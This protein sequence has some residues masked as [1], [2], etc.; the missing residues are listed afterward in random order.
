MLIDEVKHLVDMSPVRV[1]HST[2]PVSPV[3][4]DCWA[5]EVMDLMGLMCL[6]EV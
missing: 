1:T 2:E 3:Q 6:M 5:V 4:I